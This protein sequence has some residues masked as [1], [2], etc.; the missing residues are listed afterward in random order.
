MADNVEE[1]LVAGEI[2]IVLDPSDADGLAAL[3]MQI[4]P[5]ARQFAVCDDHRACLRDGAP[6]DG[7]RKRDL[8]GRGTADVFNR[9]CLPRPVEIDKFRQSVDRGA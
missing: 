9:D 5:I 7:Q 1:G 4:T 6:A 3:A 8:A 2:H